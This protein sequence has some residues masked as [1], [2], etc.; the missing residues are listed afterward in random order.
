MCKY[1]F[2]CVCVYIVHME[3]KAFV[4]KKKEKEC[5]RFI[6]TNMGHIPDISSY[7]RSNKQAKSSHRTV[8]VLFF[9]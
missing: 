7:F 3:Q 4:K 9:F 6:Y 5:S 8:V 2:V 1:K